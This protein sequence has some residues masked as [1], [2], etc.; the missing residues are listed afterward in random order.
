MKELNKNIAFDTL[1]QIDLFSDN[2]KPFNKNELIFHIPH[3]SSI[4]PDKTGYVSDELI[5]TEIEKLTDW[6]TDIIFDVDNTDKLIADFSRVYCD[7]ER[8]ENDLF[9]PM[10]K[11]GRGFFYTHTD[12][13]KLLRT[14]TDNNKLSVLKVYNKHHKK[15]TELT[16]TKLNEYGKAI[17]IDCHSFTDIPFNTDLDKTENRPDICIGTD[18]FHTPEHL[19]LFVANK[20]GELGY[21]VEI[22]FPYVGTIVPIDYYNKNNIQSIMIE[23]NR[24]LYMEN[25][26]TQWDNVHKLNS[27][28]N[29]IFQ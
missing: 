25:N 14:E 3:S 5:E 26:K 6:Y 15:L 11:F 21:S 29:Y 16:Q 19:K 28:I 7:V 4:I 12:C 20:F 10:A 13:G 2:I 9:E 22:N 1:N 17:I 23:I 18:N 27:D 24:K 8:F